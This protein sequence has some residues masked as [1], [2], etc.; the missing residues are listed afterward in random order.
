MKKHS[1]IGPTD[2]SPIGTIEASFVIL[3]SC[4]CLPTPL[5]HTKLVPGCASALQVLFLQLMPYSAVSF[6][7]IEDKN[8]I[9]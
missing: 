9:I 6:V 3:Y 4:S 1:P 7:S 5:A 2:D 8:D